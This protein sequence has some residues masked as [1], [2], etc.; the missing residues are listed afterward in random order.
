[1]HEHSSTSGTPAKSLAQCPSA[2]DRQF[3]IFFSYGH[4]GNEEL[5]RLIK[6]DLE[7]RGHD[8]WFD[9]SEIKVGDD[10]RRSI[11][12]GI[13]GSQG[14]LSFLSKHS[15]RDPGVCLDEIAIAI[16]AKG[17]NIQ[18]ILVESEGEVKPPPSISH[19]QWLDM[20]DWKERRD[21]GEA[22]WEP[23]YQA[24]LA[25]IVAVV[26]S[27]ES[28]RFAGEIK[29]LEELLK[30]TDSDFAADARIRKLLE[31]KLVGRTWL[32]AA[33]AHLCGRLYRHRGQ[34]LHRLYHRVRSEVPQPARAAPSLIPSSAR[35]SPCPACRPIFSDAP[36]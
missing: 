5:V 13:V 16:G 4:D 7:K 35:C 19:I 3:S 34:D 9:K 20:H 32:P 26:E 12:D 15:T 27:D 36:T 24:K 29:T 31:K 22:A 14:V 8:V 33:R 1:M 28:R 6:A 18:T 30:P 21:A 25:E 10:W 11:T 2:K 17:G 23:W